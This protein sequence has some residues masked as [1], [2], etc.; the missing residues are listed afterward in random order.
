[1]KAISIREPWASMIYNGKKTIETRTWMTKHRGPLLLCAS[2]KPKSDIGGCAF[3][4]AFL[5]DIQ[6]MRKRDEFRACCDIYP[7]AYSWFL[8]NVES[9]EPFPVKGKLSLFEVDYEPCPFHGDAHE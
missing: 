6:L 9:I 5:A 3:A 7:G 4:V 8:V 2:K 1:M